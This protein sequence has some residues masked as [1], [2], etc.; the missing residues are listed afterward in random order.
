MNTKGNII[1]MLPLSTKQETEIMRLWKRGHTDYY[2]A[3]QLCGRDIDR[4]VDMT[5]QVTRYLDQ[6]FPQYRQKNLSGA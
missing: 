4:R 3:S 2:I 6:S 5:A 1:A